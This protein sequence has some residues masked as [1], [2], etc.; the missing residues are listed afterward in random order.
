MQT[1]GITGHNAFCCK[2]S[3][4]HS[5]C[6]AVTPGPAWKA[7]KFRGTVL[8]ENRLRQGV[9]GGWQ[10]Q[11]VGGR[12]RG[13]QRGGWLHTSSAMPG[14]AGLRAAC[15]CCRRAV[16]SSPAARRLS[17]APSAPAAGSGP[18]D[19][20]AAFKYCQQL[21][22]CDH[23]PHRAA[24][25]PLSTLRRALARHR[26]YELGQAMCGMMLP[27]ELRMAHT[28]LR[29]V[30]IE[31]A[32]VADQVSGELQGRMRLQWW[33]EAVETAT[34]GRAGPGALPPAYRTP[35]VLALAALAKHSPAL[36][37]ARLQTL[38]DARM[39][40]L[41][42]TQPQEIYALEK[43]AEETQSSLLYLLL[44]AA[45]Y[46]SPIDA[47]AMVC[48]A[49]SHIGNALGLTVLLQAAPHHAAARD[50]PLPATIMAHHR[51]PTEDF[52]RAAVS[53]TACL[54]KHFPSATSN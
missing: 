52:Y 31:T 36:D 5:R 23:A 19:A 43:Y 12:V 44:Q 42:P 9:A 4:K 8:R 54:R 47:D 48:R 14:V 26:K 27:R 2:L 20:A 21:V 24:L 28:V 49:A 53:A 1:S 17:T 35:V 37:P 13:V 10:C 30:N 15:C 3:P 46:S 29:A 16:S 22:R 18:G 45:G 11:L 34:R 6:V 39:D 25:P 41:D 33:K 40:A 50:C 38:I 32:R 51:V 7:A